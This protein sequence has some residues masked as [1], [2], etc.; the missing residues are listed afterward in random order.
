MF[1]GGPHNVNRNNEMLNRSPHTHIKWQLGKNKKYSSSQH[2]PILFTRRNIQNYSW[3]WSY[4]VVHLLV[5]FTT[6]IIIIII[7]RLAP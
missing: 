2:V 1:V 6:I 3:L 5:L 7:R 4:I